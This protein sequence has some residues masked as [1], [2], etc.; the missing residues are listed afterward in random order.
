M[1]TTADALVNLDIARRAKALQ[2]WVEDCKTRM[3]ARWPEIDFDSNQW[4][5]KTLY[6]TKILNVS[7][8]PSLNDFHGKD[9][10]YGLTL[11]CL[12]AEIALK[13]DVK[14]PFGQLP[15]W[16]LL[17]RIDVPLHQLRRSDLRELEKSLTKEAQDLPK[18]AGGLYRNLLVLRAHIDLTGYKGVTDR[19]AWNLVPQTKSQLLA[20]G[21]K[22]QSQS[23]AMKALVLDRQIEALSDAQ[24]AMLRGDERLSAYDRVAL[25]VVGL[26]MC[27]PNR[28]NEPLC[29]AIDDRFTLEDYLTREAEHGA[30]ID[31][32][33]LERSH[34]MLL[35]KGSKGAAWGAKPVLNFMMAFADLCIEVIKQHGERSRMLISW[36]EKHP[37]I[38][39]LPANL[40]HLRGTAIDRISLWQI[41]NMKTQVPNNELAASMKP[42]WKELHEK[43]FIQEKINP[44]THTRN[45][46]INPKK[47]NTNRGMVRS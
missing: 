18:T 45:G 5:L 36:Y 28:V 15:G 1:N 42:I 41:T 34:Q 9:P 35:I 38:L 6:K 16:R 7:F 13:G 10:A 43:G 19:L 32:Q 29:M 33:T 30:S 12:M 31:S 44:R 37:E 21:R 14:D 17:S 4:P 46:K 24:T 23:K 3:E 40:E 2:V 8:A 20:L 11:K 47:N 39:Y 25:A 27:C 26:N 22:S